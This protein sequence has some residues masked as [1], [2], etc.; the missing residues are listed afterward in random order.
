MPLVFD[1]DLRF[2]AVSQGRTR[3]LRPS[4]FLSAQPTGLWSLEP[5]ADDEEDDVVQALEV[6]IPCE[7]LTLSGCE[8]VPPGQLYLTAQLELDARASRVAALTSGAVEGNGV[9]RFNDGRVVIKEASAIGAAVGVST[10]TIVGS[11]EAKPMASRAPPPPPPAALPVPPPPLPS[12]PP[13]SSTS[14]PQTLSSSAS[15]LSSM[16]SSM[17][18]RR[19]WLAAAASSLAVGGSALLPAAALT[20]DLGALAGRPLGGGGESLATSSFEILAAQAAAKK[21]LDDEETYKT[22]VTMGLPTSSLSMPPNLPFGLFKKYEPLV[23]DPDTF[24]DAAIEYVE[25]ARDGNDLLALAR[26]ARTNGGGPSAVKDY[27]E[28]AFES[29]RGAA[30]ALDR[31]V[32]LLPPS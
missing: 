31:L 14:P 6:S 7:G 18:P 16:S 12:P 4:S 19:A 25:Y 1:R 26:M 21:L 17:L 5:I 2:S 8:L 22:M 15:L 20:T 11:L 30:K 3:L 27:V 23:K 24:M 9:L 13:P 32:P 10:L 29:A 28:R